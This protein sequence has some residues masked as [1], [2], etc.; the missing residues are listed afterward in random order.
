M[1]LLKGRDNISSGNESYKQK[2]KSYAKTLHWNECLRQDSYK[3]KKD[4]DDFM[5]DTGLSFQAHDEFGP[6]EL[7]A[8][9]VLLFEIA[10]QLWGGAAQQ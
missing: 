1:L 6:D 8:R 9:Q 7:E 5:K 2:L 4:F 3:S 10:T